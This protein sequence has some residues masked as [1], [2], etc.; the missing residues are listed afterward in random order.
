M[1]AK[2]RADALADHMSA[3]LRVKGRGLEAVAAKAGRRLPKSLRAEA[4]KIAQA[5]A[6][7]EHPRLA[8]LIDERSLKRADRKVR[9]YL[10]RQ[11]PSKVRRGEILDLIAKIAFVVFTIILIAFFV[12]LSRGAFS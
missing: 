5:A 1:D 6:M 10:D 8:Y 4:S 9:K 7:A 3:Q 12:L 2:A 11:N